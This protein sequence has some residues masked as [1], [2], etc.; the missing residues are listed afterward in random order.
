MT[1][2][3]FLHAIRSAAQVASV[4]ELLVFGSQAILL[5]H[6]DPPAA[7]RQSVELDVVP[8]RHPER[9]ETIDGPLGEQSPFHLTHGF[10]VHGV[11][12]ETATFPAHWEARCL[13]VP[14][15]RPPVVVICPELHDLAASKLA[16]G[17]DKD[18]N[19]VSVLIEHDLIDTH[20]LLRRVAKLPVPQEDRR[21]L[22]A[23][24]GAVASGLSGRGMPDADVEGA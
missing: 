2:E 22:R 16:A 17:R 23:W 1:Y 10:Y 20:K 11:G 19:Y 6:P 8:Y 12:F 21:R 4:D 15:G 24:I 7:L 14:V 18:F 9:W 13:R 3:E 5:M